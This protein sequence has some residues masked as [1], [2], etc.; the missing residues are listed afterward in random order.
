MNLYYATSRIRFY[1]MAMK[2]LFSNALLK[3]FTRLLEQ[4]V[5][6]QNFRDNENV[7]KEF[8]N[9]ANKAANTISL[10]TNFR[11]NAYLNSAKVKWKSH[12]YGVMVGLI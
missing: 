12:L 3:Y 10:N 11:T 9:P 4:I 1:E 5:T 7:V 2:E 8:E 6:L